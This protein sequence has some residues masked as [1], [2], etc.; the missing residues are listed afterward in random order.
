MKFQNESYIYNYMGNIYY[1]QKKF[2]NALEC[3]TKAKELAVIINDVVQIIKVNLNIAI[4]NSEVG[5]YNKAIATYKELEALIDA[6]QLIYSQQE[7][8]NEKCKINLNIGIAFEDYFNKNR[9]KTNLI[10]SSFYYYNKS[11]L[12][13]QNDLSLKL[14]TLKILEIFTIIK[15]I[16]I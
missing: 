11:L 9:N 13:S 7:F 3:Y 4:I 6:N 1:H 14:K 2:S 12:F 15:I 8:L 10:D 5:N 16:L